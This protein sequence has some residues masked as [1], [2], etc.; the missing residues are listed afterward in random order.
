[1]PQMPSDPNAHPN[2]ELLNLLG[3]GLAKFGLPFVR[4]FGYTTKT[5]FY[6]YFVDVRIVETGSVVKNRQDLFDP[7]F[8]NGRKGWWQKGDTYLHR[9][10]AIDTIC[11]N[12]NVTQ[13]ATYVKGYIASKR[14]IE[15]S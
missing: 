9:K 3:Y 7:F 10:T 1:M 13:F 8:D 14:Y 5:A 6:E 2:Y 4:E 15:V 11:G 12:M